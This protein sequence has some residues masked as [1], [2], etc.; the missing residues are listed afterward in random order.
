MQRTMTGHSAPHPG[1]LDGLAY[2]FDKKS[3][4]S[5]KQGAAVPNC[6]ILVLWGDGWKLST[7]SDKATNDP[8]G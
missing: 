7:P 1:R 4:I 3:K 5:T 2:P 6:A 8:A